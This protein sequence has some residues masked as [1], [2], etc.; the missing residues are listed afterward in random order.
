MKKSTNVISLINYNA[1]HKGNFIT[2]LENLVK[3]LDKHIYVFNEEARNCSWISELNN[4]YFENQN[5]SIYKTLSKLIKENQINI[6]HVHFT[7]INYLKAL[8]LISLFHKVKIIYHHHIWYKPH[9]NKIKN[10]VFKHLYSHAYHVAVS[11]DLFVDLKKEFK[12]SRV[13]KVENCIDFT[14]LDKDNKSVD[15]T[16]FEKYMCFLLLGYDISTKGGDIATKAL[17]KLYK[18]N[19]EFRLL[20][21]LSEASTK[22]KFYEQYDFANIITPINDMGTYYK[23]AFCLLAP[24]RIEAFGYAPIEASYCECI[25]IASN[26]KGQKSVVNPSKIEFQTEDPDALYDKIVTL[27]NMPESD[28]TEMKDQGKKYVMEHYDISKWCTEI[29]ELYFK[30]L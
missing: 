10:L 7:S 25:T 30:L 12:A 24:S 29:K 21:P 17:E 2:S 26:C 9:K 5:G 15:L 1:S 16:V 19:K 4:V 23:R 11:E 27:I 20:V 22:R 18:E 8:K 6:I 28:L 3:T 14:R 13:F